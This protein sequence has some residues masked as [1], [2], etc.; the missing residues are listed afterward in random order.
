M[1]VS[2]SQA[3]QIA[4]Q[5]NVIVANQGTF[6]P[7]VG[8]MKA[9]NPALSLYAYLNGTYSQGG[10][11][12]PSSWYAQDAH[13]GK[14]VSS[15]FGNF[16]MDPTNPGWIGDRVSTCQ[17]ELAV[18]HYDGCFLDMLGPATMFNGYVN[19]PPINH[20]TGQAWTMHDWLNATS[21]LAARVKAATGRLV[22]GNGLASGITFFDPV[23]PTSVLLGGIDGA[24]AEIWMR[25]ASLP[26]TAFPTVADW[27][28]NVNMLSATSGAVLTITKTWAGGTPTQ[29]AVWH[30][31]ALASFLLGTN[32]I[33]F[34][35][36]SSDNTVAGIVGTTPWDHVDI[37]MPVGPYGPIAGAYGRA[38]TK[39]VALVN[40]GSTTVTVPLGA[41]FTDLSN[42]A[43]TSVTLPP[44]TGEVLTGGS[45]IPPGLPVTA[46]YGYRLAG[47]DG[48]VLSYGADT[49]LGSA[50]SLRLSRP[51]A[52]SAPT[53]TTH[54]YW[55]VGSDGGIFNYGDAAFYGSAGAL[56]LNR[57]IVGM[58]AT[59]TGHGYWLVASDGGIF[60]FGDAAF[61]GS[62][63]ALRLNR[64]IVGM[65]ATPTG[66]GYWLVAS[67]GGIFNFGDAAFY[68]ST[69]ALRLNRP[70]VGMAATPTGHGYWL[71]GA[72]GGI[73]NIGDAGFHGSTGAMVLNRPIVGVISSASGQGY[74][75]VASDGGIFNFGDAAFYGSAGATA[76]AAPIVGVSR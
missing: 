69:G 73:F 68:G 52:G 32:G 51:I 54:G 21:A 28:M 66:H 30:K 2:A 11:S 55:L 1:N 20:S 27:K 10:T 3:V 12:Y 4:Q 60:N 26:V 16:L 35:E 15:G 22:I 40:P 8:A 39:G 29:K 61:Y 74:W 64:P 41:S 31:F 62:A 49:Y 46:G 72:D 43:R 25:N 48:S 70:I 14:V 42:T 57:P 76:L 13:G 45:A 53:P 24:S 71:V 5:Y 63:G 44:H 58:A 6:D 34:F 50:N 75:L 47:A 67:D 7:F 37:G 59:P 23:A 9:A 65:A 18:S 17:S 36:F 33:D 38:F 19:S 56:R